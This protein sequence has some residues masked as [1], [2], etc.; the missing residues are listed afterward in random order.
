MGWPF[1]DSGGGFGGFVGS[2]AGTVGSFA[3][4]T[5]ESIKKDPLSALATGGLSSQIEG[6]AKTAMG[7]LAPTSPVEQAQQE[8]RTP[9]LLTEDEVDAQTQR[10][11][12]SSRPG[13]VGQGRKTTLTQRRRIPSLLGDA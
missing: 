6:A 3:K 8:S 10:D 5:F 12:R 11:F 9:D 7:K 1:D 2:V 4:N 13:V